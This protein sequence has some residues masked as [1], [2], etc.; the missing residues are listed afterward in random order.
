MALGD[1]APQATAYGARPGYPEALV[2]LC[3]TRAG[4]VAGDRVADIGAG[5]GIF[6]QHLAAR[7]LVVDAVE[8]NAAMRAQAPATSGVRWLEGS[9]EHTGLPGASVTWVT[10]AQAFHWA[11]PPRALP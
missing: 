3:V 4:V 9:F 1:F 2:D 5:T 8:P 11:D 10:A 6:T 7:G